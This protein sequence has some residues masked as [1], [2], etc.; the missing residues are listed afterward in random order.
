MG[1]DL[2]C[3]DTTDFLKEQTTAIDLQ[4]SPDMPGG[5]YRL[6][7]VYQKIFGTENEP[8][9]DRAETSV[10]MLL[11]ILMNMGDDFVTASKKHSTYFKDVYVGR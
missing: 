9:V 6:E 11:R 10:D 1:R 7:G 5:S 8:T 2:L 4:H 3:Y